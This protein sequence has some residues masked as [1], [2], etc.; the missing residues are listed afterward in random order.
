MHDLSLSM[1]WLRGRCCLSQRL[2]G[3]TVCTWMDGLKCTRGSVA[4]DRAESLTIDRAKHAADAACRS[5][6]QREARLDDC[7][8]LAGQPSR[9]RPR[10]KTTSTWSYYLIFSVSSVFFLTFWLAG[11]P[12]IK[13]NNSTQILCLYTVL[14]WKKLII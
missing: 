2:N 4:V 11:A 7:M 13:E 3:S 5:A 14:A 1:F 10:R 8:Q 9:Q 6:A 12:N